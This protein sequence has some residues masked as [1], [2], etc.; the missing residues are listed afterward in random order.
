MI[1]REQGVDHPDLV[2]GRRHGGR[3]PAHYIAAKHGVTGLM[4]SMVNR[5]V[6]PYGI[7]VNPI[8]PDVFETPIV[9]ASQTT[10]DFIAGGEG[11]G[12]VE[13][14]HENAKYWSAV[15]G[16]GALHPKETANAVLYLASD[17]SAAVS[18]LELMVDCGWHA[19]PGFNTAA[20]GD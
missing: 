17:E 14:F 3:A 18:G 19:L 13:I 1:E 10:L 7:R 8:L 2:G 12:S 9:T 20:M 5:S 16:L 4:K 6:R 15:K 11:K